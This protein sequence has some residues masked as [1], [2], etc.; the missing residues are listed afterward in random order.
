MW[1]ILFLLLWGAG[2]WL[3]IPWLGWGYGLLLLFPAIEDARSGYIS[4]RW[5]LLLLFCGGSLALTEGRGVEALI[6]FL[7]T[8]AIYGLL[9]VISKKSLGEGDMVLAAAAAVWLSPV[10]AL[11]ALWLSAVCALVYVGA[12]VT[13]GKYTREIRFAPFIALGGM[14]AYGLE[15]TVGLYPLLAGLSFG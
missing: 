8:A 9:Y 1:D 10:A 12:L 7:L 11:L 13:A 6:S 2:L 5:A 14:I 4:D 3:G 15:Q